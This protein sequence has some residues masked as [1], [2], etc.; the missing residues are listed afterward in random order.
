MLYLIF[1]DTGWT[2]FCSK[3][4]EFLDSFRMKEF[5]DDN[6][7]FDEN[8]GKFSRREENT[9]EKREIAHY[10]QFLLFIQCF[11]KPCTIIT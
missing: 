7:E 9:V 4:Y 8:G 1:I 11:Q 6:F 3:G 2:N 5:A 10:E